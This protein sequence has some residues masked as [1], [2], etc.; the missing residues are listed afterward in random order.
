MTPNPSQPSEK[1]TQPL[2]RPDIIGSPTLPPCGQPDKSCNS[3]TEDS[4]SSSNNSPE[5]SDPNPEDHL[6]SD[7]EEIKNRRC[8]VC[9][10]ELVE[11]SCKLVCNSDWCRGLV[12]VNCSDS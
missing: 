3:E 9:H 6:T 2:I 10:A 11:I 4:P 5:P 12:V 7:L 1:P 8:P